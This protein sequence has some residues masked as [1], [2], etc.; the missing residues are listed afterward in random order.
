MSG[1]LF[2]KKKCAAFIIMH[3]IIKPIEKKLKKQGV[4]DKTS[5]SNYCFFPPFRLFSLKRPSK[6][7]IIFF[8]SSLSIFNDFPISSQA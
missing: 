6:L 7:E 5:L 4:L 8:A 1:T 2:M 3:H